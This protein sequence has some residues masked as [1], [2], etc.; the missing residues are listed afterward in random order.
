MQ[1]WRLLFGCAALAFAPASRLTAT[2]VTFSG[3]ASYNGTYAADTLYA[4]VLDTAGPT[5]L[6]LERIPAGSPPVSMP[7]ALDFDN[8]L[9]PH[10]V[11]VAAVLDV[12]G[13]GFDV[14]N[15]DN[16]ITDADVL[17]WYPGTAEPGMISPSTS[18]AGLDFVLPTGE[19][20]GTVTFRTG[21][22]YAEVEAY[23]IANFWS[24]R[25]V[26][27]GA[28][29]P[30]SLRGIYAGNYYVVGWGDFGEVCWGDPHCVTPG[31]LAL[32]TGE[33]R[34]GIDLD[35][36][37]TAVEAETWGRIKSLYR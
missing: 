1:P 10:P 12:D 2:P 20:Q 25:N 18:H 24:P 15:L 3:T 8:A 5:I 9:A 11:I 33:I 28:P 16:V 36:G 17:G 6:A 26:A 32:G 4:A 34:T 19:I 27:L 14:S 13:S 35:F 22:T 21:Q 23:T 29:G 7:F 37:L 31:V 30:Y